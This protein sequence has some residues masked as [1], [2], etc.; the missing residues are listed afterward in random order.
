MGTQV[1]VA[2]D[3]VVYQAEYFGRYGNLIVVDH[4]N[5]MR[6]Y[7][8][9]LSKFN[10]VPGQEVRRGDIVG[11]S[12]ATGAVTAPHLHFEVRM[13]GSAVNPFPYLAKSTLTQQ[14]EPDFPF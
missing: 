9:H 3:G 11:F 4:G 2:A 7:Y 10:V 13:G 1:H 8:A 12:G 6:T 14:T 5:G